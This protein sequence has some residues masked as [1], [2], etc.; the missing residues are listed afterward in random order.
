MWE[1]IRRVPV[2]GS[3]FVSPANS[4]GF[5]DGGIDYVL[6]RRIL[7]G[8]EPR[9][10]QLISQSGV[11][12]G[13]D[14]ILPVGAAMWIDCPEQ[15]AALIATP[16]M[17]IPSE[18]S[19]TQNAYWSALAAFHTMGKDAREGIE[20]LIFTSHCCGSGR[21]DP[22][23]SA[24]QLALAYHDWMNDA[25]TNQMQTHNWGVVFDGAQ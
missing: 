2:E 16:T 22:R 6:S 23:E 21:M 4:V 5:M 13:N 1:D 18:V 24:R 3:V 11:Q 14:K 19:N 8:V 10:M 12:H 25:R 7:P 17:L 20:R 9:L 15:K